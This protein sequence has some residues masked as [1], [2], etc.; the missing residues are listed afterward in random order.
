MRFLYIASLLL[1]STSLNSAIWQ[2]RQLMDFT[3]QICQSWQETGEFKMDAVIRLVETSKIVIRGRQIGVKHRL[4]VSKQVYLE[5]DV[6]DRAGPQARFISTLYRAG[7]DP[8]IMLSLSQDCSMQVARKI[9]YS[10]AGL[11]LNIVSLD[12]KLA[13]RGRVEWLN[14]A[15]VFLDRDAPDSVIQPNTKEQP[16]I[17]VG[18]VDSGVNYAIPLINRH[19]ARDSKNRLIGYDFW[20][21]DALPY[22]AHPLRS[23]FFVQ[24]HGTRTA[25]LLLREA[26]GI[27]LVPYRYPRPDMSRMKAL[28]EH[29]ANNHV[30][31][32][33]MPLGSN[34]AGE[35]QAF[36]QAAR[37]HPEMLFIV[38]AGNNGRNID[39]DPVYPA[40]LDIDNM[41]VVTSAD[42]FVRPAERTNWGAKSVDYL[43]PAE[44]I[45]LIGFSGKEITASGSSYAVSRLTALAANLKIAN[46]HWTGADIIIELHKRYSDSSTSGWVSTGYI[47]DPLAGNP[48]EFKPLADLDI[49]RV[50]DNSGPRLALDILL[51]DPVWTR[52]RVQ[53]TVQIASDIL[54]QCD[55]RAEDISMHSFDGD[56]YLRDLSTGNAHTLLGAIN[57]TNVRVIF[58]RDTRMQDQFSG[59]AFGLGNTRRRP[60]LA[61]SVWL[62]P[63]VE[64]E[65]LALAHELFHVISNSG[66]HVEDAGNLMQDRTHVGSQSLTAEQCND[67]RVAGVDIG[68]LDIE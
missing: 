48:V 19:L 31:V 65:G 50:T 5:L 25:S 46:R 57:S 33:G 68:L 21:M 62:M 4:S 16:P 12:D 13:V 11:A 27:E 53:Q 29:A 41:L 61:N 49:G 1:I 10:D 51:L 58:A 18:M 56:D 60:W 42:D 35:W 44:N 14:P 59:E 15:L 2:P 28:V 55:I 6:I 39:D 24:R 17:R 38:S 54:G 45:A 22:D 47:A 36:E 3:V 34:R 32:L 30:S 40:S 37:A 9:N 26:P 64:D 23:E 8:L 66:E 20:D 43:I 67:A 63:D 7:G 52:Q